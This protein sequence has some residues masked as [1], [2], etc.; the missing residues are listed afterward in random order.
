MLA[1]KT[2]IKQLYRSLWDQ[3]L[4]EANDFAALTRYARGGGQA[5]SR[6]ARAAAQERLQPAAPHR[7]SPRAGCATARPPS[8]PRARCGSGCST[9]R[10]AACRWRRCSG[11]RRRWP[12]SWRR[13]G[14]EPA[15]GAPGLRPCRPAAAPR[16]RGGGSALGAE[17]ARPLGPRG[18]RVPRVHLER[19]GVRVRV[20]AQVLELAS[21]AATSSATSIISSNVVC[22][23]S[24][25][26]CW[27][28][29]I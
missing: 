16:G 27:L 23:S 14:R 5:A 26:R 18:S 1:A 4:I 12:P 25:E 20:I 17:G 8:R 21:A 22:R 10:T 6:R 9:S 15:A 28:R 3:G 19:H 29:R 13:P 7:R 24:G 2:Y 11:T